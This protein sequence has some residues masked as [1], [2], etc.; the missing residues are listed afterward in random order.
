MKRRNVAAVI[1]EI[2]KVIPDTERDLIISLKNYGSSLWNKAPELMDCSE[3][4][5]PVHHILI[6]FIP[7]IDEPWKIKVQHIFVG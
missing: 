2:L 7:F 1:C 4:W 3:L 5:L 6:K